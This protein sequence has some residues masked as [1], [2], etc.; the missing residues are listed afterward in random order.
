MRSYFDHT[1]RFWREHCE[2]RRLYVVVDYENLTTNID[3]LEFYASQ[4]KRV[5]DE[6]AIT[7]VRYNG[8]MLQ[9]MAGR[10]TALKLH[11]TSKT[12]GSLEEALE[13]VR[14]LQRGTISIH[15]PRL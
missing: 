10:M 4:V 11:T 2:G 6:M 5:L 8:T 15:P 13:V 12:Y 7:I 3:E 9:R 1:L 14:G